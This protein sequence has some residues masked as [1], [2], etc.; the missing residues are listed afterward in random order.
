MWGKGQPS[1]AS[2]S[3]TQPK[4]EWDSVVCDVLVSDGGTQDLEVVRLGEGHASEAVLQQHL[5]KEAVA[6]EEQVMHLWTTEDTTM[7]SSQQPR[8][9]QDRFAK[10]LELIA[11]GDPMSGTLASQSTLFNST[12]QSSGTQVFTRNTGGA[13]TSS[14]WLQPSPRRATTC[15]QSAGLY[16]SDNGGA[17]GYAAAHLSSGFGGV[18]NANCCSADFPALTLPDLILPG[19]ARLRDG[20]GEF[21]LSSSSRSQEVN[22][23]LLHNTCSQQLLQDLSSLTK[24]N[25]LTASMLQHNLMI[26]KGSHLNAQSLGNAMPWDGARPSS[27]S[28][29][30]VASP[31]LHTTMASALADVGAGGCSEASSCTD[32]NSLYLS[33]D[34]GGEEAAAAAAAADVQNLPGP[35]RMLQDTGARLE[36]RAAQAATAVAAEA[37]AIAQA[38]KPRSSTAKQLPR[39]GSMPRDGTVG[40]GLPAAAPEVD[41]SSCA[42]PSHTLVNKVSQVNIWVT[43]HPQT[44]Q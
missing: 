33:S 17:A 15:A 32:L 6:S 3:S 21:L 43:E 4:Q 10:K 35:C 20:G 41:G 1:E 31:T 22:T 26:S 24:G 42:S 14:L 27:P 9:G 38:A 40:H 29:Q 2:A 8:N 25:P 34:H 37:Q 12:Q 39:A 11:K 28:T 13:A 19:A 5:P 23:P 16:V 36:L 18:A 7:R 30:A 44:K